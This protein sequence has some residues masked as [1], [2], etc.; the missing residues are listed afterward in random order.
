MKKICHHFKGNTGIHKI[1]R[2]RM[3]KKKKKKED[4]DDDEER[5]KQLTSFLASDVTGD[6]FVSHQCMCIC[7]CVCVCV[8]VCVL[9]R[10]LSLSLA[11]LSFTHNFFFCFSLSLSL[12]SPGQLLHSLSLPSTAVSTLRVQVCLYYSLL[13]P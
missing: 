13:L 1:R 10:C 11:S 2:R 3:R 7:L 8:C 4:D 9:L 5:S 12:L 6:F